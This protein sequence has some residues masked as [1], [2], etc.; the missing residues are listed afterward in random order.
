MVLSGLSNSVAKQFQT[1]QLN[2]EHDNPEQIFNV[3]KFLWMK[4]NLFSVWMR[5]T[6]ADNVEEENLN[7][8]RC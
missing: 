8:L 3:E 4:T 7:K 6:S 2:W 5:E 1:E